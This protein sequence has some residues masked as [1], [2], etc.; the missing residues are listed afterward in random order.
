MDNKLQKAYHK[1]VMDRGG[2]VWASCDLC[3]SKKNLQVH[4][5]IQRG[6]VAPD[7][8]N[9]ISIPPLLALLCKD[10]HDDAHNTEVRNLLLNKNA[11]RY[12]KKQVIESF[13]MIDDEM[14]HGLMFD[15]ETILSE[16]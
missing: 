13:Q 1:V 3:N 2:K 7:F 10:C 11:I 8:I 9:L 4:H 12:G 14:K 6:W 15:I 5:I 16:S